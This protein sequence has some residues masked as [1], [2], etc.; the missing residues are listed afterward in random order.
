MES[1][2]SV[3]EPEGGLNLD[4]YREPSILDGRVSPAS[5]RSFQS[6][7]EDI[8]TQTNMDQDQDNLQ[9]VKNPTDDSESEDDVPENL[10]AL[11]VSHKKSGGFFIP[12]PTLEQ[13]EDAAKDLQDILKPP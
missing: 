13:V 3:E 7:M 1:I 4:F 8:S 11:N 6:A 5:F 9:T 10:S 12:A 2:P